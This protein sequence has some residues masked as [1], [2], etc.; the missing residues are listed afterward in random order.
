MSA[1]GQFHSPTYTPTCVSTHTHAH[2]CMHPHTC[3]DVCIHPRTHT[4][5]HTWACTRKCTYVHTY[6]SWHFSAWA[7]D[8]GS[9]LAPGSVLVRL[10]QVPALPCASMSSSIKWQ[11]SSYVPQRMAPRHLETLTSAWHIV[12]APEM[13]G[14][15]AL[16]RRAQ[17]FSPPDAHSPIFVKPPGVHGRD[18]GPSALFCLQPWGLNPLSRAGG[19]CYPERLGTAA[20]PRSSRAQLLKLSEGM[21]TP[22]QTNSLVKYALSKSDLRCS[23]CT[24]TKW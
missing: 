5:S 8:F 22:S 2:M 6:T 13:P 10:R 24:H 17:A 3:R 16:P 15:T 9:E 4:H 12:G 1:G 7:T 14:I 19:G 11:Q 18:A 20:D 23:H 21:T